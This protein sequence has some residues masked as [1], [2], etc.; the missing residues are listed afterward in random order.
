MHSPAGKYYNVLTYINWTLNKTDPVLF[1]DLIKLREVFEQIIMNDVTEAALTNNHSIKVS[2]EIQF[3]FI[4][5]KK[6][7]AT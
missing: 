2:V 4:I 3:N 5:K 1:K 7:L 6:K